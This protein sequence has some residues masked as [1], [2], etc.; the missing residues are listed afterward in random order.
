MGRFYSTCPFKKPPMYLRRMCRYSDYSRVKGGGE[1]RG[2]TF[3]ER[4]FEERQSQSGAW[5]LTTRREREAAEGSFNRRSSSTYTVWQDGQ[6]SLPLGNAAYILWSFL[7]FRL[8]NFRLNDCCALAL[9][10]L[11]ALSPGANAQ[12]R[13]KSNKSP[14][15]LSFLALVSLPQLCTNFIHSGFRFSTVHV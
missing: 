5:F 12:V 4:T 6:A 2:G 15:L 11:L 7:L 8:L 3:F 14:R 13:I 10:L 9:F 1:R